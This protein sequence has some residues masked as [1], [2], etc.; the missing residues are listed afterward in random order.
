MDVRGEQEYI[1]E[2][3]P[4]SLIEENR[5][6]V[7][8]TETIR[9]ESNFDPETRTVLVSDLPRAEVLAIPIP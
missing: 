7:A 5:W 3:E 2:L 8:Q 4:E 9:T 1:V 6:P